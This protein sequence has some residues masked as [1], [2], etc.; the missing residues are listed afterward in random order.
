MTQKLCSKELMSIESV[1]EKAFLKQALVFMCMQCKFS[2][3]TVEKGEIARYEN[4]LPFLS[5]L[6]LLSANSSSFNQSFGKGFIHFISRFPVRYR[7]ISLKIFFD[8]T[9]VLP[10]KIPIFTFLLPRLILRALQLDGN[11]RSFNLHFTGL[12]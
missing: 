9:L 12:T 4:C 7:G 3:N 6:K 5:N 10:V 8:L 11:M 2:E 1:K